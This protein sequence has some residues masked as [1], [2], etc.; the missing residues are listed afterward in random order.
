MAK[1]KIIRMFR[2]L[3]AY[4]FKAYKQVLFEKRVQLR[5]LQVNPRKVESL[6]HK[7]NILTQAKSL[8][9]MILRKAESLIKW[10]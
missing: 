10:E 2:A 5:V 9:E 1:K 3:Q 7:N 6:I 4:R 8:Q